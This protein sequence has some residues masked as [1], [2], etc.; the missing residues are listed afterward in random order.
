MRCRILLPAFLLAML[1]AAGMADADKR[2]PLPEL[3]NPV[4]FNT[5]EADKVLAALQIFPPDNPW[6][7]DISQLPVHANSAKLIASAGADKPLAYNLDM[8]F[9][10]VPPDQKKV[11]VK[12]TEYPDESDK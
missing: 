5:P 4:L 12:I 8:G 2:P 10:L 3:K 1:C 7:E 6:N 11:P 9:V